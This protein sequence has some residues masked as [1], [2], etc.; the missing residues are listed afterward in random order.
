MWQP[1]APERKHPSDAG[2]EAVNGKGTCQVCDAEIALRADGMPKRAHKR[3]VVHNPDADPGHHV[4]ST[5]ECHGSR[6]PPTEYVA[7]FE[8]A[9]NA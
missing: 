9:R 4:V 7:A 2:R 5:F 8:A 1:M 3:T 6:L